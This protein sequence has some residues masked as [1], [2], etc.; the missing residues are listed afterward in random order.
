MGGLDTRVPGLLGTRYP[1]VQAPMAGGFTTPELVAAIS[2]AGAL[3][4]LGGATL[5]PDELRDAITAVRRLTDRP[6]AVNLFAPLPSPEADAEQIA[7][8]Q[9]TLAPL[10]S[11]LGLSE[12]QDVP[13]APPPGLV[14][15]QLAVVAEE[16][17]PVFSFTFGVLPFE[18][19]RESGSVILGTA[20]T[21]AEAVE[22]ERLGVDA[23]VAQAG[24]AGGHRG[25]FLGPFE[26]AVVGGVALVP[27]IVDR[28]SV[29]V[30]LAG[31]IMDGRGIAAALALGAEGVQ[32]G[33][34]FLGCPESGA[35]SSPARR[36]RGAPADATVVTPRLLGEAG[37]PRADTARRCGRGRRRRPAAVPSPDDGHAEH[38]SCRA[39]GGSRRSALRARRTGCGRG[40]RAACGRARRG[41][42][43]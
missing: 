32:L 36:A 13:L 25:T 8:M 4:S 42:R 33:T 37:A 28:V 21:A 23:I 24:E 5:G 15:A 35:T 1:I 34:A 27:R 14:E 40:P 43:P 17:V 3:G 38:P 12:P 11:E 10:R 39:R 19:I 20:T 22:L 31:G 6:F 2:N 18:Q 16:C 9:A 7:A 30:L 26:D 41:A 29:P